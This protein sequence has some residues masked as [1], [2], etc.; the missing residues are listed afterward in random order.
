MP[1][2]ARQLFA[3]ATCLALSACMA[4]APH[5]D[6][7]PDVKPVSKSGFTA[8]P[9][10]PELAPESDSCGARTYQWLVGKDR[11]EIPPAPEGKVVRVLCSTCMM[12]MDFNAAR[13]NIFYEQKTGAVS[14]LSC[15]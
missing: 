5:E 10:P 3:I 1:N 14:R 2:L 13:L 9:P 6:A 7:D 8:V 15:G 4:S 11:K 12:T